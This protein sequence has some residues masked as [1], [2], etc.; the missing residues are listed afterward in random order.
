MQQLILF[1]TRYRNNLLLLALLLLAIIRH[2]YK[3]PVSEH[4]I[5]Q[6]GSGFSASI[7]NVTSGW[8]KYWTL[9]DINEELARE[10][11]TLR[12]SLWAGN[13]P[14]FARSKN[15]TFIPVKVIDFSFKKRNNYVVLDGGKSTGIL[16]GMGVISSSGWVGTVSE[17]TTNYAYVLP[18][19]HSRGEIGARLEGKGLGQLS[20]TGDPHTGILKDIEREFKPTKGDSVFSYTRAEIA[21][22]VLTG[23]VKNAVQSEE[24][25]SW[26]AEVELTTDFLNLNWVYVCQFKSVAELD[27]LKTFME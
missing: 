15:Y 21:P 27:S 25:L 7:S 13:V 20:W 5:N 19:T 4:W 16:P 26:D 24:D 14:D 9:E 11:A 10:N 2:S 17:S 6:I 18:F 8:K 12:A 22:P 3:N 23:I 1:L